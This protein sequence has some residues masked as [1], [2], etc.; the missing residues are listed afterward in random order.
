VGLEYWIWPGQAF[1][2]GSSLSDDFGLLPARSLSAGWCPA[3][4]LGLVP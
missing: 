3:R 1:R 2:L 4:K